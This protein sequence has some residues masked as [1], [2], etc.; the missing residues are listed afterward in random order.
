M[1]TLLI[2]VS[3]GP[4]NFSG[5]YDPSTR[6]TFMGDKHVDCTEFEAEP[7]TSHLGEP[8]TTPRRRNKM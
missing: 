6:A 7:V 3:F 2:S 8:A 5:V 4:L 1:V